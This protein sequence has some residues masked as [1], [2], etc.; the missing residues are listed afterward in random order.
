[1]LSAEQNPLRKFH[2]ESCLQSVGLM[3]L[4]LS[5]NIELTRQT[6][7]YVSKWV[8][9]RDISLKVHI[10]PVYNVGYINV[11]SRAFVYLQFLYILS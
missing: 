11:Y 4:F 6:S 10:F 8:Q 5:Y 3:F 2:A 9:S 7:A 1:M